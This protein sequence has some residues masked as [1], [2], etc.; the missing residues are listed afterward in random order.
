MKMKLSLSLLFILLLAVS[1][2]S[3][4]TARTSETKRFKGGFEIFPIPAKPMVGY[5]SNIEKRWAF[6]TKFTY[7]FMAASPQLNLELN[8]IRR[9][10]RNEIFNFYNGVGFAI[11]G[12]SPG[13]IVPIGF[14]IKPFSKYP[15]IV[16]ITEA[17]PKFMISLFGGIYSGF[18][19]NIGLI[20]F[21][22]VK[23]RK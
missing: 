1:A 14:E 6:D 4:D 5:R 7:S 12:F 3:Q 19:G 18:N 23:K 10:I 11:E 21:K 15:N 13:I 2:Y 9:H 20:F 17:S 16:L 22:P 8:A